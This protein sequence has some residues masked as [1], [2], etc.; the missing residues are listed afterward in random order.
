MADKRPSDDAKKFMDPTWGAGAQINPAERAAAEPGVPEGWPLVATWP[1]DRWYFFDGGKSS[2]TTSTMRSTLIAV[3]VVAASQLDAATLR[4]TIV[5]GE[6]GKPVPA[7]LYIR[8]A[9]GKW[10]HA[11]SSSPEGSAVIYDKVRGESQEVHTTLSAHRFQ[12]DLPS[13]RYTLTVE[14]GKEYHT[15]DRVVEI[16]NDP[17]DVRFQINRWTHMARKGW[18][19][20]DTHVHRTMADLPN[21]QLAEDLNVTFPLNFWVTD[22]TETPAKDNLNREPIPPA[23]LIRLD[24]THVIWPINTE[25]EFFTVR[26]KPHT[27]GAVFVLNHSRALETTALPVGPMVK[28]ARSQNEDVLLELDKHNWP[29]SM[30]LPPVA[31][32]ELFELTNN[33]IWRTKFRF[34]TWY[35]EYAAEYM[36]LK[37]DADGNFT[38]RGWI[39]FGFENYYA[40]LNCGFRMWP[41]GGTASGV[42]PVPLGFGRVYVQLEKGFDYK[43]WIRGL[44]AGRSFVTTGPMLTATVN[45]KPHG[46]IFSGFQP[47][48]VQVTASAESAYPLKNIEVIVNGEVARTIAPT[49]RKSGRGAITTAAEATIQIDQSSWIALRCFEDRPDKRPRFAHTSPFHFEV[50]GRPLKPSKEEADYLIQR[51]ENEIRRH[52]DVLSKDV[53][54]EFENASQA[55]KRIAGRD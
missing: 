37:M 54:R 38:E 42:H 9:T 27:L 22:S 52:K 45:G 51:V 28:A 50:A 35:R 33:H 11:K 36:N 12:A 19:G 24:A 1:R 13:G 17:V 40:L 26:R 31:G 48:D 18:F 23:R 3:L 29:W 43:E 5:D 8:S 39:D 41:T 34:S 44:K 14:R 21:V 4:G 16:K 49:N 10:F 55:Y 25:Y 15:L 30:M 46:T 32:V 47:G 20:G 2:M 53:L 6:G 7:R